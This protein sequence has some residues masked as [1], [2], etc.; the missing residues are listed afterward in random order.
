[1]EKVTIGNLSRMIQTEAD[2]YEYLETLRWLEKPVCPHCGVMNDHYFLKPTNGVSRTTTEVQGLS[3]AVLGVNWDD[4]SRFQG[5]SSDVALCLFRDVH[6]Q[7][8]DRR[9]GDRS[10]VRRGT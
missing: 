3:Q 10:Q 6:E 5:S 7:E 8:R 1:M 4:L 2:A 9:K